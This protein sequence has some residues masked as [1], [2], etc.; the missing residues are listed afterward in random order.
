MIGQVLKAGNRVGVVIAAKPKAE[1]RR[2][3]VA[4][5]PLADGQV[6]EH[7]WPPT[8]AELLHALD[9]SITGRVPRGQRGAVAAVEEPIGFAAWL[10]HH[11]EEAERYGI[12]LSVPGAATARRAKLAR[13]YALLIGQG[14]TDERL[15]AASVGVLDDAYMR[16][17][18]HVD[19]ENVLR[20]EKVGRRADAGERV[21]QARLA[22][23]SGEVT[24]WSAFDG[25][26]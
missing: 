16:E 25:G 12:K 4:W 20:V 9:T 14:E 24:D 21:L 15:R 26:S 23:D 8:V 2:V 10:G 19:P 17:N 22:Q 13:T 6:T 11:V 5:E 18:G 7:A 3:K 1:P